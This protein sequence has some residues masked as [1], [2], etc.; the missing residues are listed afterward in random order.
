[1]IPTCVCAIIFRQATHKFSIL[2]TQVILWGLL[3]AVISEVRFR[4]LTRRQ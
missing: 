2:K 3:E 1:M 4:F